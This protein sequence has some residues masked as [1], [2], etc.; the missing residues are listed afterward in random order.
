MKI[1]FEYKSDQEKQDILSTIGLTVQPVTEDL[2]LAEKA[3][4]EALQR[5]LGEIY[6]KG[7]VTKVAREN[8]E[9]YI[10]KV[11]GFFKE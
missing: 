10:D 3:L 6:I 8:Q 9:Q 11:R 1:L 4:K 5:V 2:E 7:S